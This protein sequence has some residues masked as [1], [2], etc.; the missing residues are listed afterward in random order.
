MSTATSEQ[1]QDEYYIID[2]ENRYDLLHHC[3]VIIQTTCSS[4][5]RD[6]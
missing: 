5:E 4:L 1:T 2:A 6:Q 3:N